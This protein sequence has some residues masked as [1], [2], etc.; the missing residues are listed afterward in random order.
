MLEPRAQGS[1][2][3]ESLSSGYSGS[4]AAASGPQSAGGV[5]G[6]L[7]RRTWLAQRMPSFFT[8]LE[9]LPSLFDPGV[10]EKALMRAVARALNDARVSRGEE[11]NL[12]RLR[13][14]ACLGEAAQLGAGAA[15]V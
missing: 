4:G 14:A 13:Y 3:G 7:W 5:E 9:E 10:R 2:G 1:I 15:L 12:G 6:A 8:A 11:A